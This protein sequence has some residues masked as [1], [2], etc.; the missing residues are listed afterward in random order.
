MAQIKLKRGTRAQLDAAAAANELNQAEP[1]FVT[2]ENVIAVGTAADAYTDIGSQTG[3]IPFHR[4]DGTND[5]IAL[6]SSNAIPFYESDGSANSIAL[7]I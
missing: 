7:V 3:S 6:T 2:D 5:T 4:S 1:Y